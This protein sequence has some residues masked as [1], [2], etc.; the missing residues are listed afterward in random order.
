MCHCCLIIALIICLCC[1]TLA[2]TT[3]VSLLLRHFVLS[4]YRC[5]TTAVSLPLSHYRCLTTA[6]LLP[7]SHYRCLTTAVS[8]PLSH[9]CC[10]SFYC[11]TAAISLPAPGSDGEETKEHN[12]SLGEPAYLHMSGDTLLRSW[13]KY[14]C[15][16]IV[17]LILLLSHC[18]SRNVALVLLLTY[19]CSHIAA[20]TVDK[21]LVDNLFTPCDTP[22]LFGGVQAMLANKLVDRL[23]SVSGGMHCGIRLI[24]IDIKAPYN[25]HPPIWCLC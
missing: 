11:L 6:V 2:L 14:S 1:L 25:V 15:S 8:L 18:C 19:C 13:Y 12:N 7:L 20:L 24:C 3:A 17:G 10:L 5:L 23:V 9:Y 22:E 21:T 16:H 4:H